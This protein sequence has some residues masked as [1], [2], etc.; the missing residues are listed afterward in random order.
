MFNIK[1]NLRMNG[2]VTTAVEDCLV[3]VQDARPSFFPTM[4]NN[5]QLCANA[6]ILE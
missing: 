1:Q 6:I 5:V 2:I 3:L 4:V